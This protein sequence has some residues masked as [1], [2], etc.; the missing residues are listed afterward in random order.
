MTG[1][2]VFHNH[3]GTV[4]KESYQGRGETSYLNLNLCKTCLSLHLLKES[5]KLSQNNPKLY[6]SHFTSQECNL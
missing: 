6:V 4:N 5:K 2:F 3:W 1:T